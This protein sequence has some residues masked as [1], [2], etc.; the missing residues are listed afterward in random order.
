MRGCL[1]LPF[2]LALLVLLVVAGF[3]VWSYRREIRR[4]IHEW[5]SEK[6]T[7]TAVGQGGADQAASVR[8]RIQGL[9]G[10]AR[11]S[12]VLSAGDVA[13]LVAAAASARVPGALDSIEVRL[14]NDDISVRALVDTR[15]VPMDLGS[16]RSVI[17]DREWADAGGKVVFRRTGLAEWAVDRARI[18]GI[19]LPQKVIDDV[20]RRIAGRVEAGAVEIALPSAVGGLRVSPAGVVLY[21]LAPVGGLR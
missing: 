20:L 3:V 18:R 14:D 1:A 12:V 9:R 10:N 13:S 7:P 11:D 19:P 2:R 6:S 16:L 21:G 8:R 17:R 15:R 4:Q 5:T